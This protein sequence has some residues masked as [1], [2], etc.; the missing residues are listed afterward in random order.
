MPPGRLQIFFV[1]TSWPKLKSNGQ[2]NRKYPSNSRTLR[3]LHF[4]ASF[5]DYP[6]LPILYEDSLVIKMVDVGNGN[7][8]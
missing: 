5:L 6:V 8:H 2:T 7:G 4:V 3:V 1:L